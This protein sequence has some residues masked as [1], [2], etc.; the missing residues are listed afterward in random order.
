MEG[1]GEPYLLL[2]TGETPHHYSLKPKDAEKI[3]AADIIVATSLDNEY[4][5]ADLLK[6]LRDNTIVPIEMAKAEGIT[7]LATS[8][9]H[10]DHKSYDPHLWLDPQNAIAF[11]GYI[12]NNLSNIDPLHAED[13]RRNAEKQIV[14]LKELDS[15]MQQRYAA[16]P[17]AAYASYHSA[18]R[19]FENRYGIAPGKIVTQVPEAGPSVSEAEALYREINSGHIKCLFTESDFRSKFFDRVSEAH[20]QIRQLTLDPLGGQFAPSP[21]LYS[22]LI[23]HVSEVVAPCLQ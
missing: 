9:D 18:L 8:A 10:H 17:Q 12:A 1:V 5:I 3:R 16:H 23:H 4:Y 22:K 7:L 15:K 11:T 13:Y 19:Y 14:G 20:P 6:S 2:K 21:A